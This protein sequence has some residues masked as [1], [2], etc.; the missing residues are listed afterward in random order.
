MQKLLIVGLGNPGSQYSSNR[1]NIGFMVLDLL[2]SEFDLHFSETRNFKSYIASNQQIILCKPTTYMNTSGEAVA[3]LKNYFKLEEFWVVYDDLDLAFGDLRFK[4][5]GGS[6][7][8]NGLKSIDSHCGTDYWRARCGI[9][10]PEEKCDVAS[11]VLSDFE[12]RPKELIKQC[13][14]ALKFFVQT[15]DFQEMQNRFTKKV[16]Q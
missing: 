14:D 1:H 10:R 2:A 9:G 8:H 4:R 12:S 11:Y 15:G 16:K 6:G 3:L 13:V 5:G 7:G